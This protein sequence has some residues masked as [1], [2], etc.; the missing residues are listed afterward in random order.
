MQIGPWLLSVSVTRYGKLFDLG[1]FLKPLATIN[2]PKSPTFLGIFVK[3]SKSIIFL[4][5]SFLG[6]FYRHLAFFSGHTENNPHCQTSVCYGV[7]INTHH[8]RLSF[9]YNRKKTDLHYADNSFRPVWTEWPFSGNKFTYKRSL[10]IWWLFGL[11]LNITVQVQTVVATFWA[12]SQKF[13]Y[14]F[15]HLVTLFLAIHFE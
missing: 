15:H 1:N 14:F 2:L 13:S 8:R 11:F 9:D 7:Y 6:N 4:V 10:N 3:V 5:K 12:T